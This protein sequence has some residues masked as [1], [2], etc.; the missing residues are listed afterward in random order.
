MIRERL[1][2]SNSET[3]IVTKRRESELSEY[4][5]AADTQKSLKKS[6]S[7]E[8]LKL[9]AEEPQQQWSKGTQ[10]VTIYPS[11]VA[12]VLSAETLTDN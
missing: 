4:M 5:Q 10:E 12:R 6:Y 7:A 3:R 1:Q 11:L 8:N 9:A 2:R